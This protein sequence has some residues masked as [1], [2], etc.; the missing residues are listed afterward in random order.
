ML[1]KLLK[2]LG[3]LAVGAATIT[4]LSFSCLFGVIIYETFFKIPEE[5]TVPNITGKKLQS[6]LSFIKNLKLSAKVKKQY[7]DKIPPGQIISQ[8]PKAGETVRSGREISIISSIGPE[9]TA[10][11]DIETLTQRD[12]ELMLRERQL[13]VGKITYVENSEEME[14][15]ISQSPKAG[16]RVKKG[17]PVSFT[18]NVGKIVKYEVPIFENKSL[19]YTYS[20]LRDSPFKLGRVRWIYHDYIQKGQVIRQNPIPGTFANKNYP[21]NLDVSAG[22]MYGDLIISQETIRFTVPSDLSSDS[23]HKNIKI[24]LRDQR[25]FNYIY[26]ADHSSGDRIELMVTANGG[27]EAYIYM[28]GTIKQKIT[29]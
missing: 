27:A 25:G 19:D 29:I 12:G 5:I 8:S 2:V 16:E 3:F 22:K 28:D 18:V 15:I 11:P 6:S 9:M 21:I 13:V 14:S 26:D 20:V 17:S 10:V 4:T 23:T 7:N 1:R 24:A